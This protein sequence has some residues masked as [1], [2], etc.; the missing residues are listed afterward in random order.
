MAKFPQIKITFGA[1]TKPLQRDMK[2]TQSAFGKWGSAIKGAM[3]G[4]A[5]AVAGFA[6]KWAGDG[7]KAAIEAEKVERRFAKTLENVTKATEAQVGAVEEYITATQMATGVNDDDLRKSFEM[8]VRRTKDVTRSQ[9]LQASALDLSAGAGISLEAATKAIMKAQDGQFAGLRKLGIPLDET[10]IKT[11]NVAKAMEI[12]N[13]TVGGQAAEAAGTTAGKYAILQEQ[14]GEIQEQVGTALLP[15]LTQFSDWLTE[16]GM[17]A[18]QTFFDVLSGKEV[19]DKTLTEAQE[20]AK[21][22]AIAFQNASTAIGN[23][24]TQLEL[25]DPDGAFNTLVQGMADIATFLAD[26]V[27]FVDKLDIEFGAGTPLFDLLALAQ[28][29]KPPSAQTIENW[30]Y[31]L[32]GRTPPSSSSTSGGRYLTPQEQ[33]N[34]YGTQ[35][36]TVNVSGALDPAATAK[37]IERSLAQAERIGTYGWQGRGT[38]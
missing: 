8:L 5:L 35:G 24:F 3:A 23:M 6:A 25:G 1:D 2:K 29:K 10:T 12:L 31:K 28:G 4:A 15:V 33:R 17:A 37:A 21:Q 34:F 38:G 14:L 9:K 16:E 18:I 36:V 22:M 11:K 30:L 26:I 20:S 7:V 32:T 27:K 19:D 13:D